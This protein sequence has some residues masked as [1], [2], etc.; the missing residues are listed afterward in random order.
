MNLSICDIC[1]RYAPH[2]TK[3]GRFCDRHVKTET[4]KA[5]AKEIVNARKRKEKGE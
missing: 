2:T 1:S 5:V 4:M 3:W